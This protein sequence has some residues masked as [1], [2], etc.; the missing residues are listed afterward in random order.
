MPSGPESWQTLLFGAAAL[1]VLY[2]AWR[3]W[4]LGVV[5]QV[6]GIVALAAGYGAAVFFG[7]LAVPILRPIGLP[8]RVL[9]VLGG[10]LMGVVVYAGIVVAGGVLFKRTSQQ[11]VGLV[12]LAYGISGAFFGALLGLLLVSVGFLGIRVLGTIAQSGSK[13]VT[14]SQSQASHHGAKSNPRA[15]APNS[16]VQGLAEMKGALDHGPVGPL[17]DHVDPLP[18]Q[19]Y[20]TVA[21]L[22]QVLASEDGLTRLASYPGLRDAAMTPKFK[23]LQRDPDIARAVLRGEFFELL[24]NPRVVEAANDPEIV[25]QIMKVDFEKALDYALGK[26]ENRLPSPDPR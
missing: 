22:G 3:G 21:K 4:R 18:P 9:S 16:M 5:R 12:R 25:A 7:Y 8:D 2:K 23:A 10:A 13:P 15:A 11:S 20:S 6:L 14:A 17:I 1:V 26:P 24:R 19:L